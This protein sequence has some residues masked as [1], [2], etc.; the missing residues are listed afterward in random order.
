MPKR[1]ELSVK[2]EGFDVLMDSVKR[3]SDKEIRTEKN[4]QMRLAAKRVAGTLV[5]PALRMAAYGSGAPPQAKITASTARPRSDRWPKVLM[6]DKAGYFRTPRKSKHSRGGR[7]DQPRYGAVFW[8]S[9]KG[10]PSGKFGTGT[11]DLW[12][13]DAVRRVLPVAAKVHQQHVTRMLAKEGLL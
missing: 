7:G 13:G 4:G 12:V 3:I 9:V 6:G 10:G 2:A 5:V 11:G 1:A 8:G